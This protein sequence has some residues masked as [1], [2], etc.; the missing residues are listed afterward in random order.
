[1]IR[2]A[3]MLG[4]GNCNTERS[5]RL[6]QRK[7]RNKGSERGKDDSEGGGDVHIKQNSGR[8]GK[9]DRYSKDGY[10]R[11][12]ISGCTWGSYILRRDGS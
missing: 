9:L 12:K 1:V 4:D 6:G 11:W 8:L 7:G 10:N 3:A 2:K 5:G